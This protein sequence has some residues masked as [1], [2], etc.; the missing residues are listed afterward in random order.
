MRLVEDVEEIC[1]EPEFQVF[2]EGT[3]FRDRE[4]AIVDSRTPHMADAAV[5]E[6]V[7]RRSSEAAGIK[8]P[9]DG[10]LVSCK[11]S[12]E[13]GWFLTCPQVGASWPSRYLNFIHCY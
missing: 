4:I 3:V 11:M 13:R 5:P 7:C 12:L 2:T 9:P 1:L 10:S 6:S 8:P